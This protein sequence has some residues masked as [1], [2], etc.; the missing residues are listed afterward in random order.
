MDVYLAR[1]EC[2][3]RTLKWQQDE[4]AVCLSTLL[5]GKGLQVYRPTNMPDNDVDDY[6]RLKV[7]LLKQ[8]RLTE[9][10]KQQEEC[11]EKLR[12]RDEKLQQLEKKLQ[13]WEAKNK[14]QELVIEEY[15]ESHRREL[16]RM[17]D[18]MMIKRKGKCKNVD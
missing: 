2:F 5:T 16:E 17:K 11:E 10:A 7:D 13:D 4:W 9:E 8:Y 18:Y 1:F 6:Y 12:N 14:H 3:A 15:E